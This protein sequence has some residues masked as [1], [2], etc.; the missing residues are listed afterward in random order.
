MNEISY[1]I[2][3]FYI[4]DKNIKV[5]IVKD[6]D[7][8]IW[9]FPKGMQ[10]DGELPIQTAERELL[11]E[12][13]VRCLKI[14]MEREFSINYT[15]SSIDGLVNKQ[16]IFF[17]GLFDNDNIILQKNELVD[18]KIVAYENAFEKFDFKNQ[19]DLLLSAVDFLLKL[20]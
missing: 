2:I 6:K 14:F 10:E 13:N 8:E 11:E 16:S 20:I 4:S 1:G 9:N 19:K 7:S 3:P 5:L 15:Y 17:V 18:Y 12:T